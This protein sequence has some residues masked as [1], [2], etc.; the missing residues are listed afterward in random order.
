M[1]ML[2]ADRGVGE[3]VSLGAALLA[4]KKVGPDVTNLLMEDHRVVLGWFAWY[5]KSQDPATK[6]ALRRRICAALTAHMTGEEEIVYPEA[7]RHIGDSGLVQHAIEEHARAKALIE[8]LGSTA[9]P[10]E[11]DPRMRELRSDIEEHVR[12]EETALF[13]QMRESGLDL[14]EIGRAF[15]ARRADCLFELLGN[16]PPLDQ[17]I[18]EFPNM[19]ISREAARDVFVTGLKNAHASARQG[20][21]ML[22]SQVQ[23]LENYP[24]LKERL[25]SHLEKKDAQL[26]RLEGILDDLG[27]SRST[28]KDAAMGMMA[29][30]ASMANAAAGDEVIKNGFATLAHAKFE[31]A[32]YETLLLFGEAA[33][34]LEHLR[35]IQQS[36]SEERGLASFMEESLRP[37]GM[38]FLELRS[39]GA[40]ASH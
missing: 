22:E 18:R 11:A 34:E 38:R 24:K 12:E 32:A 19:P 2:I 17:T 23:R 36:L 8:Q 1:R 14:H 29:S 3:P 28:L 6:A 16:A 27:E 30:A 39:E 9:A 31:T 4:G 7:E 26:A 40:Q 37:T 10:A 20:R 35:P 5:E 13:P 15:A 25:Q 33:G 21:T